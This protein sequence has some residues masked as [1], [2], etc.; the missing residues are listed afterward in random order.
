MRTDSITNL[1][2]YLLNQEQELERQV[3][4]TQDSQLLFKNYMVE[5]GRKVKELKE[6]RVDLEEENHRSKDALNKLNRDI[7]EAES[8][9]HRV[10]EEIEVGT[11]DTRK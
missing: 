2:E 4:L 1:K 6:R 8:D 7:L 5:E 3:K 10:R 11:R 9:V